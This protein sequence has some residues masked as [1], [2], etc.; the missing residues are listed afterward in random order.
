MAALHKILSNI[1]NVGTSIP[2]YIRCNQSHNIWFQNDFQLHNLQ[3]LQLQRVQV[4]PKQSQ[5]IKKLSK[6]VM[7]KQELYI[8][9]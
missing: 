2:L 3:Q 5:P 7:L 4:A 1:N 8:H 6:F 9:S